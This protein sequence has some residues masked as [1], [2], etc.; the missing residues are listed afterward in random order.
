MLDCTPGAT[1]CA[2]QLRESWAG[3]PVEPLT[4]SAAGKPLEC[5][6]AAPSALDTAH[7]ISSRRAGSVRGKSATECSF[8]LAVASALRSLAG[9]ASS[10][11][12]PSHPSR[13]WQRA[14]ARK[15]GKG[16]TAGSVRSMQRLDSAGPPSSSSVAMGTS[17]HSALEQPAHRPEGPHHRP[18]PILQG[19]RSILILGLCAQ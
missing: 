8:R 9:I 16:L 11:W 4:T 3:R 12:Q 7:H 19:D 15:V 10:S 17:T 14:S 1:R 18:H 6:P 13:G 2:C 5:C